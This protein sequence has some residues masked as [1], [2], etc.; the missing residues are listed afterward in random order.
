VDFYLF[1]KRS[2]I[3]LT[4]DL[5]FSYAS[6]EKQAVVEAVV[7]ARYSPSESIQPIYYLSTIY[8]L[9]QH[10]LHLSQAISLLVIVLTHTSILP[11]LHLCKARVS[12]RSEN[13]FGAARCLN[14]VQLLDGSTSILQHQECGKYLLRARI[15]KAERL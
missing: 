15:E 13:L 7:E 8:F 3:P 12:N 10:Y 11:E 2:P 1:N 9:A 14:N 6:K 5:K 4:V